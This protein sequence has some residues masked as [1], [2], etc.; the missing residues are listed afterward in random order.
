MVN[1]EDTKLD[2]IKMTPQ[3]YEQMFKVM[4]TSKSGNITPEEI[5]N[6]VKAYETWIYERE[7]KKTME[8]LYVKKDASEDGENKSYLA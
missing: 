5:P 8:E 6:V 2:D 1:Q 4:D 3:Q 7:Y